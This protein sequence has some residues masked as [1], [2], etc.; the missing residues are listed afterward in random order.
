MA[1]YV[2]LYRGMKNVAEACHERFLLLYALNLDQIRY[3]FK[4]IIKS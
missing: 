2:I 4:D 1:I 3:V